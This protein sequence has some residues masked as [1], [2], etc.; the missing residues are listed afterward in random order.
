MSAKHVCGIYT[1]I[2][3]T[4]AIKYRICDLSAR[5]MAGTVTDKATIL[6]DRPQITRAGLV[7]NAS[8]FLI[9]F[10]YLRGKYVT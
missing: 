1:D 9:F 10:L 2:T 8:N 3:R 6:S 7:K 4:I 5:P